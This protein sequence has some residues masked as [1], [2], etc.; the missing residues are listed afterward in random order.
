MPNNA[1]LGE[2]EDPT[3]FGLNRNL[4]SPFKCSL[5]WY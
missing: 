3:Y 4:L 2:Y 5:S 1:L